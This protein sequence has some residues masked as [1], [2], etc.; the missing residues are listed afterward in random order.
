MKAADLEAM[1]GVD[2][3][4]NAALRANW[5]IVKRWNVDRRYQATSEADARDLYQAVTDTVNGVLPWIRVRW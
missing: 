2:L 4:A 5:W 1:F 3:G